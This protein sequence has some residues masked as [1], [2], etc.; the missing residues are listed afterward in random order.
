[1]NDAWTAS[2]NFTFNVGLR[3]DKNDGTDA[4]GAPVVKDAAFSPR[5][6]ATW[7]PKGD[8]TWTV[9]ASFARYVTGLANRV[10]DSASAPAA[11]RP[12]SPSTTSAPT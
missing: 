10:G 3:Y 4:A 5:L 9:N 8:G 6:S 12:T 2:K 7:D 11:S 1:M